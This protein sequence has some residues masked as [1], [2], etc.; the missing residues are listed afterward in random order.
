MSQQPHPNHPPAYASP[1]TNPPPGPPQPP[2][3]RRNGL[4]LGALIIAI[5]GFAFAVI[6][7]A[8]IIGWILLP[9]AF[10]LSLVA[11]FQ[12]DKAKKAAV[13]AL[14]ISIVGT[15]A[16]GIAFMASA[17]KAV[18]EAFGTSVTAAPPGA[19]QPSA[20]PTSRGGS[21]AT[22]QG[23]RSNPYPLGTA[24]SSRDWTV[25]VNSYNPNANAEVA[26][27]NGI[28][29]KPDDGHTYVLVNLTVTYTGAD[30]GSPSSVSVNYVTAAGN[31]VNSYDKFAM[32]P[33]ALPGNELYNGATAT[34]N[35]VLHIPE[36]DAGALRVR[37]GLFADEVFVA[38]S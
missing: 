33:D 1:G 20:P 19:E 23:S 4:A 15:I 8:Y 9:I 35:V 22:K 38:T 12:R 24:I 36:G 37:P 2:T 3:K 6:E 29:E 14:V 32:A 25:T 31:V 10:I 7:G 27:V 13:A 16:G 28:N 18:D 30:K 26:A 11:L 21:D 5:L 34:G 17:A